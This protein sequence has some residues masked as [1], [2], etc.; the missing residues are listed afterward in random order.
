MEL[1]GTQHY[2]NR[3][4]PTCSLRQLSIS[5]SP[6]AQVHCIG[7]LNQYYC[8]HHEATP[9]IRSSLPIALFQVFSGLTFFAAV[10]KS[11][12]GKTWSEA[13]LLHVGKFVHMYVVYTI[14]TCTCICLHTCTHKPRTHSSLLYKHTCVHQIN[15]KIKGQLERRL[16]EIT[17]Y[18]A[19]KRTH[20]LRCSGKTAVPEAPDIVWSGMGLLWCVQWEIVVLRS[21]ATHVQCISMRVPSTCSPG[22]NWRILLQLTAHYLDGNAK[23]HLL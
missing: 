23:H 21:D 13:I 12:A 3:C 10:E 19:Y 17:V 2:W 9:S 6:V 5:L 18:I 15:A 16:P 20:S 7:Y 14:H 8:K 4:T 11:R 22:T 1:H